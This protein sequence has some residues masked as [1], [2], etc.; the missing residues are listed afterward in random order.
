[1][2]N[3][4]ETLCEKHREFVPLIAAIEKVED[5]V[6]EVPVVSLR[7]ST[8]GLRESLAH[9]LIP[10]AIGEGR[11]VFPMLRKLTGSSEAAR[12]MNREHREIARLTD[13]LERIGDELARSGLSPSEGQALR[14]VL[15]D[16]RGRIR[17]HF[18]QE[19][20]ACFSILQDELSPDEAR[21]LFQAMERATEEIR[22]AYE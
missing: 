2:A 17:E 16:L 15:H 14:R 1:M 10:H 11:T 12:A 4:K 8:G 5:L 13:E 18:E 19:Q 9:G 22:E 21:E 20:E 7:G 6:G 3:P